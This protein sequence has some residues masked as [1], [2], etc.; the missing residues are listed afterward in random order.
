MS[1]MLDIMM[2]ATTPWLEN[3]LTTV[4]CIASRQS[5]CAYAIFRLLT[6]SKLD[7]MT[8]KRILELKIP[9]L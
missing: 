1:N 4:N 2:R 3:E 6:L 7:W 9:E 5:V 8:S